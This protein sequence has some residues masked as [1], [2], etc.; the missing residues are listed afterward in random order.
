LASPESFGSYKVIRQLGQGG[1]GA[2]YLAE[3]VRLGREVALKVLLPEANQHPQ[4]VERFFQEARTVNRVKNEHI[5]EVT[6]DGRAESG[7]YFFVM[8]LLSG[9]SLAQRLER[10]QTLPLAVA[11]HIVL[12]VADALGAAHRVG[13]VHRDVKP[14]N[15]FLI[16]RGGDSSYVKLLD[17]GIAKL[18]DVMRTKT[19]NLLGTPAYMS[20][21]QC[22][23]QSNIDGRSDIYSLGIL[24]YELLTGS[25]P[26]QSE[27]VSGFLYKHVYEPFPSLRQACA[28]LPAEIETLL[29][30]ATAKRRED[31]FSEVAAFEAALKPFENVRPISSVE[32]PAAVASVESLPT[33]GSG[34]THI[35]AAPNVPPK[36]F[37]PLG[38]CLDAGKYQLVEKMRGTALTGQYWATGPRG[39]CMVT[40]TTTPLSISLS[41]AEQLLRLPV[42]GVSPLCYVGPLE[43]EDDYFCG[44]VEALPSGKPS[45]EGLSRALAMDVA[46]EVA[47][48]AMRAHSHGLALVGIYPELI[49]VDDSQKLSVTLAPR[50]L[51]WMALSEGSPHKTTQEP[52][53]VFWHPCLA[54]ELIISRRS[55]FIANAASDVFSLGATVAT[56]LG[57]HP[58]GETIPEIVTRIMGGNP[59]LDGLPQE[60]Q[61]LLA[62]TMAREP[63]QRPTMEQFRD[64]LLNLRFQ[65]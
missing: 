24:L 21:E 16:R 30:Q 44:L 19:G 33:S 20:P 2:V 62:E 29:Q 36:K 63:A 54:P 65:S 56:W 46:I 55:S 25:K 27:N 39:A 37:H 8:E 43:G 1:M 60:L 35:P 7:E 9:E 4:S 32:A 17:F 45:S 48:I 23:G 53:V 22:Q 31:R 51:A 61:S 3:H 18:N 10:E 50:G 12:Q 14:D 49:F 42:K 28:D 59:I 47:S 41:K 13:V 40:L 38:C 52:G 34:P 57:R 15:I 26:F 6:D 11:A 64:R 5:V 58:F